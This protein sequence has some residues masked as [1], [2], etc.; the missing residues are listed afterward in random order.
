MVLRPKRWDDSQSSSTAAC[1]AGA[2]ARRSPQ[3]SRLVGRHPI[4]RCRRRSDK[5]GSGRALLTSPFLAQFS[6]ERDWRYGWLSCSFGHGWPSLSTSTAAHSFVVVHQNSESSPRE[7]SDHSFSHE[8][9]YCSS[10]PDYCN[11][12]SSLDVSRVL[13]SAHS[14]RDSQ[15]VP[16]YT[17]I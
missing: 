13:L 16:V 14:D 4:S 9:C 11:G 5:I 10:F 6:G 8:S 2:T 17:V 7:D 1:L 12:I 3:C 15:Y